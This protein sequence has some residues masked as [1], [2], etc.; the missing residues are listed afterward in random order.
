MSEKVP[1]AQSDIFRLFLLSG[2]QPKT[3]RLLI[4]CQKLQW[5]AAD[6]RHCFLCFSDL[7]GRLWSMWVTWRAGTTRTTW[8]CTMW[9]C[10]LR[11]TLW[12]MVSPRTGRSTWPRLSCTHCTTTRRMWEESCCSPRSITLWYW[13]APHCV[14]KGSV[15]II[16]VVHQLFGWLHIF[17]QL[18]VE[19]CST[20]SV[21]EN[22]QSQF[23]CFPDGNIPEALLECWNKLVG[24]TQD[25]YRVI[26]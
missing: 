22:L 2:Q 25:K 12:T 1:R 3:P 9:T 6:T 19:M 13:A 26:T 18:W 5:K 17:H 23:K 10:C 21:S 20:V 8:R 15:R 24:S 7:T 14:F 4:Y 11:M 16:D